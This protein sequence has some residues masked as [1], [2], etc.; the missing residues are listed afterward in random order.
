MHGP[1]E[2][3]S[4]ASLLRPQLVVCYEVLHKTLFP[5]VDAPDIAQGEVITCILLASF[6]RGDNGNK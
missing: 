3:T 4:V 2:F 5:N 6:H 1:S